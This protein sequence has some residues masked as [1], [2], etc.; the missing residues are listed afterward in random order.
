MIYD[1]LEGKIETAGLATR[2]Q[3]LFRMSMPADVL[4]GVMIREPLTGVPVNPEIP[5]WYRVRL[6]V[7]T[8]HVDPVAGRALALAVQQALTIQAPESY[9]ASAERGAAHLGLFY[10]DTLPIQF[11]RLE[12]NGFEWSQHFHAAFGFQQ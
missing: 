8:R 9:P 12:G 7:I 2:G 3:N 6:Q 5:G 10:P 1:I 4:A 11:P